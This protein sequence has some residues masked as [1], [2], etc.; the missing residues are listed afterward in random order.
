VLRC[1]RD[2][3][4]TRIAAPRRLSDDDPD[5]A[6]RFLEPR[7]RSSPATGAGT[8]AF[9]AGA[10]WYRCGVP[11]GSAAGTEPDAKSVRDP[12]F[13]RRI[14][15]RSAGTCIG[16]RQPDDRLVTSWTYRRDLLSGNLLAST[17]SGNKV[18]RDG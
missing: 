10:L 8:G 15:P 7:P 3:Q 4:A 9:A 6:A 5:F 18:A 14:G 13:A 12:R 16:F 2:A 17:V 11:G 1:T